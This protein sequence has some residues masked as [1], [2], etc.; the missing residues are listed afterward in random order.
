MAG[1]R[2]NYELFSYLHVDNQI[3]EPMDNPRFAR[4]LTI[5]LVTYS[6]INILLI[7][8]FL[9]TRNDMARKIESLE[10]KIE[11]LEIHIFPEQYHQPPAETKL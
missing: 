8:I 1:G 9:V 2:G 3:V 5:L 6:L 10:R 7:V 4:H 11:V